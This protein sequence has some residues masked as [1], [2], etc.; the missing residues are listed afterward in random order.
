MFTS[1]ISRIFNAGTGVFVDSLSKI[2][3]DSNGT[4]LVGRVTDVCL[5]SNS[6]LYNGWASIGTISFQDIS[7]Q[8]PTEIQNKKNPSTAI[9]LFANSKNYPLVDEFVI[10][11]RGA[12]SNNPQTS[13]IRQFYYIPLN[14]WNTQHY[15][16]YPSPLSTNP[17]DQNTTYDDIQ[18]GN[19]QVNSNNEQRLPINGKSG[20]NFVEKGDVHPT[21]PF[22]GDIIIEGRNGNNIRLGSTATTEGEIKNNWSEGSDEGDPIMILRNGQPISSSSEGFLP[23]TENINEDPSSIYLTSKQKIPI[24]VSTNIPA[25]GERSTIP[26]GGL[27]DST[28]KSPKSFNDSQVILA[29]NRLLFNTVGDSILMSS[30]KNIVLESNNDIGIRSKNQNVNILAPKGNISIGQRNSQEAVIKGTSYNVFMEDLLANLKILCDALLLESS[31]TATP[32][33]ANTLKNSVIEFKNKLD[34]LLSDK[35]KIS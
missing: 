9:P 14:L 12:S 17:E 10:L 3:E 13:N 21:L 11:F 2:T 19:P 32:G 8:T 31:L 28:P 7:K 29:S 23:I 5:N 4:I 1:G 24:E 6:A 25:V 20:G 22:A 27:V 16:G 33:A 18:V 15:N 35:V 26:F 30:D 34:T